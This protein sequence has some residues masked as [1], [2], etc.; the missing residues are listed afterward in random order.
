MGPDN[1]KKR[2]AEISVSSETTL[3][4]EE[5]TMPRPKKQKQKE[6][7]TIICD[8]GV[9]DHKDEQQLGNVDGDENANVKVI[10]IENEDTLPVTRVEVNRND[11]DEGDENSTDAK[12]VTTNA[13]TNKEVLINSDEN[14]KSTPIVNDE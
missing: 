2:K 11:G 14:G 12:N 3:A 6:E 10:E 13:I 7:E 4:A 1:E 5:S 8:D 9:E